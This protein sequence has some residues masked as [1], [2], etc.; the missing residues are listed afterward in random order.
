M[1]TDPEFDASQH[2]FYY[3]RVMEIPTPRWT[4]IQA[5][6]SGL[7]PP[8]TVPLTGQGRAWSSPIWYTP[9]ADA[10]KQAPAGMTVAALQEM[11][12][13]VLDEAQLKALVVGKAFWLRN[14]VT[15]DQFSQNFTTEGNAILFRVGANTNMPSGFGNV[16]RDG[17]QGTNYSYR[18]EGNELVI[19]VAQEPYSYRFY[20]QGEAYYAA[21]SN[22]FGFANYEIIPPPQVAT[23]PLTAVSNQFSIELGLTQAQ[24]QQIVPMLEQE[25]KK[26][27]TV[28][29]D[30]KLSGEQKFEELRKMGVS[31]DAKV[32]PLL[33]PAQQQKFQAVREHLR[34][35]LLEAAGD[36][37]LA[38]AKMEALALFP[39]VHN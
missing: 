25:L 8:D 33:S 27:S 23:N 12:A 24:K 14:N 32:S 29:K 4:L 19:P 6:Q 9:S 11:G 28:S 39:D 20:Q 37:A 35:R 30:A 7:T 3:A 16:D 22:E 10:R 13:K 1:W 17:Y 5:V 31:F 26:L 36:K 15:G 38:A 34:A 2:A 21:R 18:I